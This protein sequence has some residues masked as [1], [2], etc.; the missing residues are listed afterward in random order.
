MKI[1]IIGQSVFGVDVY[2]LLRTQGHDVVGVFTI[3]DAN[4]KS[5]PLA[6]AAEADNVPVFKFPRW[7]KKVDGKFQVLPE[8]FEKY[9][10]LGAELNV[11]PFCS[12]F[13]PM[14]VI[15]K[16]QHG[17]IVYHPSILP[18]HR[19]ASAINWSLMS[20]DRTGGFTI[21][22]ADEGLDTGPILLQKETTIDLNDTVDTFYN[23]FLY[24]EGVKSMGEAV[25]LI[26]NKKAP[27]ITQTEWG[28]TYDPIWRKKSLAEV[29]F[30]MD[31]LSLH[32]FIRGNDKIPGAW[33]E[34]DGQKINLYGC[35]FIDCNKPVVGTEFPVKGCEKN[36]VVNR[37][38]LWLFGSDGRKVVVSQ[39]QLEDG[40]TVNASKFGSAELDNVVV[41]ELSPEEEA[42]K[43]AIADVW[44]SILNTVVEDEVDFFKAGAG[45]M[46]VVRLIEEIKEKCDGLAIENDDVY[47]NTKFSDFVQ[48]LVL[49]S[50]GGGGAAEIDV[51]AVELRINNM[52]LKIP[53]KLFINGQFVDALEG[54][55]FTTINPT[56]E[57]VICSVHEALKEDVDLAV[58]GAKYQFYEGEW[59]KMN[60]R[61]RGA[62]LYKLAD[63]MEAHAEELATLETIDSGAVYTLALKTH[64]G[65][66]IAT[67]RYYAGW[68]DKILGD[69]VPIN[70]ATPNRNLC[71]T[72]K[73][74]IGP[75]GLI[76]PWNYPLM[77]LAW[78][79]GAALAAGNTVVIKP[80]NVTPLT[81]L[82]WAELTA[83]AGFPPGTVSVLPGSGS[84]CGQAILDHPDIRKVGFTGS[85]GIGVTV[86]E[87][88]AKS[89]LKKCSLELGGKSPLIIFADCD[90]SSAVRNGMG[91]VFFNK[92]ENCIAAGRLFVERS[93]HDEFVARAI[94]ECKKM[95]IGDPLDRSTAHGPQNH[96]KH[97]QSLLDFVDRSV[98]EGATLA[99]GGKQVDRPGLFME[100]TVLTD[101]TDDNFAAHEESFGPIMIIS[102]FEDGD[103]EGVLR[104]ANATEFGLASGVFTND[105]KKALRVSE[106]LNCGTVFINTYNKTDVAAP[107]GGFKQ[108]GFGKDL[109]RDALDEYMKTKVI[110]MEY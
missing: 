6:A 85:T 17:S 48:M 43:A 103:M 97:F 13:I 89:N 51:P 105:I 86:M 44:A 25:R 83:K 81:A 23:R 101:V 1:A 4:G 35:K 15:D 29:D 36:A 45:S 109:G 14:E 7:R 99:Y 21:F 68:C 106:G 65:M 41:L 46:D 30:G 31:A 50:R 91:S 37:Y 58:E 47:M 74:P 67:F 32:N 11:M 93:I 108:S 26:A 72:K 100:P 88:C 80:A 66:S 107:F 24:P 98:E 63:L 76:V 96:R 42:M 62:L 82:K 19:G 34:V 27:K 53:Y 92:G 54:R 104:R 71:I 73:E 49:K 12:Q 87:S 59:G 69:T 33:A 22:Y 78:K 56:D 28:A 57:S 102:P 20:G 95:K 10:S 55:T 3:P 2:N 110:T 77:M 60:A 9:N 79:M 5:D 64:I 16:P 18:A 8:V 61:D 38:G 52:D 90:M 84:R 94:E 70:H 75:V 39:V 40:R